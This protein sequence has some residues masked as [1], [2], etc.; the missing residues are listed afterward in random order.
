[1]KEINFNGIKG[2]VTESSEHGNYLVIKLSDRVS[3]CGTYSNIWNW[4]EI[5]D[6]TSGFIG[7]LTYIGFN[8]DSVQQKYLDLIHSI[9][10]YCKKTED[11]KRPKKRVTGRFT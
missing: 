1:M 6:L 2:Q 4:E 11:M 5:P 10:G 9:N 3:I 8:T 7:F